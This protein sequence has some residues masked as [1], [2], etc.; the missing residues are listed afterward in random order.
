M[1]PTQA[2]IKSQRRQWNNPE[3]RQ[4][5]KKGGFLC[6]ETIKSCIFCERGD[7]FS[8]ILSVTLQVLPVGDAL[9]PNPQP[10]IPYLLEARRLP[11]ED[12]HYLR[13][14]STGSRE[15]GRNWAHKLGQRLSHWCHVHRFCW[16]CYLC[17]ACLI[18]S[19]GQFNLATCLILPDNLVRSGVCTMCVIFESVAP[20]MMRNGFFRQYF[21]I[22]CGL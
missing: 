22:S 21:I 9:F 7:T 17:L 20:S 16:P 4:D 19:V 5:T 2:A 11:L 14:L 8:Q 13:S 1:P 12:G 15:P 6:G 3:T 18:G 10:W